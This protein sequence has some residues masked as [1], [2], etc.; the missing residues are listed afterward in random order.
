MTTCSNP[1][2]TKPKAPRANCPRCT[3]GRLI[4][5]ARIAVCGSC[6]L[7]LGIAELP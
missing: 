2:T 1:T 3:T 5:G 7:V 6:G 4:F